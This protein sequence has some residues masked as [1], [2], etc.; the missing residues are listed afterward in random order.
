ML[1]ILS[2]I[3]ALAVLCLF[4]GAVVAPLIRDEE[5]EAP[6]ELDPDDPSWD[7][8]LDPDSGRWL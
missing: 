1:E 6:A 8:E 2:I 7:H 4:I 5:A 3:V